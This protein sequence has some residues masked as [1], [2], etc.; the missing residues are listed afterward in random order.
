[1]ITQTTSRSAITNVNGFEIAISNLDRGAALPEATLVTTLEREMFMGVP[2]VSD[3]ASAVTRGVA[4]GAK[5]VQP[6]TSTGPMGTI[7]LLGDLDGN[8]F[9]VHAKVTA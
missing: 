5:V 7:A 1:M 4:A 2:R 6:A 8:V 3:V 9:G